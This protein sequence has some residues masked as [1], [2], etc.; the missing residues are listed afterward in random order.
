MLVPL[1]DPVCYCC[2]SPR[3]HAKMYRET[4][5]DILICLECVQVVALWFYIEGAGLGDE[6]ILCQTLCDVGS[7]GPDSK[8]FHLY[9]PSVNGPFNSFSDV[10]FRRLENISENS[11]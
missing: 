5:W 7:T 3:F 6:H 4:R 1:I 11:S 10:S 2:G 8:L 9:V